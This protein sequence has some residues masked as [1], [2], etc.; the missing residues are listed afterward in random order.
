LRCGRRRAKNGRR[1]IK[2]GFFV[3]KI[4]ANPVKNSGINAP[5]NRSGARDVDVRS[6]GSAKVSDNQSKG[7]FQSVNENYA[8]NPNHAA[9][10][11]HAEDRAGKNQSRGT[12]KSAPPATA[13]DADPNEHTAPPRNDQT[14][15]APETGEDAALQN[16]PNRGEPGKTDP[17]ATGRENGRG[18]QKVSAQ[19]QNQPTPPIVILPGEQGNGNPKTGG[20]QT[21][22]IIFMPTG[23]G[24]PPNGN[25]PN[26]P[27][28]LNLPNTNLPDDQ[29][30]IG[31]N[32][33]IDLNLRAHNNQPY[34]VVRTVVDQILRQNDVYL[35]RNAFNR[36]ISHQTLQNPAA[37]LPRE[38]NTFVR[39]ISR[40]VL[41]LLDNSQAN[42]KLIH[43]I[44][45]EISQQIRENVRDARQ[46]FLK[47][48]DLG[49]VH[50][51]NLNVREKMHVAVELL[52]RHLPPKA[53]E[54]LQNHQTQEVLNGLLLARGL[55]SAN[56]QPAAVRNLT[57]FK[58]SVQPAEVSM[59]ALRDV[60]QLVRILIADTMAAKTTPNLDLA[61]QKFVRILL[62]NNELGVLLATVQLAAQSQ[63]RG[64]LIGRSLALA[65]IY[66]LINR[67]IR[68]GEVALREAAPEKNNLPKER[69]IFQSDGL[70]AIE[71]FDE[72]Q[73][74]LNKLRTN[75]SAGALRQFLE[76]NPAF[77]YDNSASKFDN[78]DDARR[79]QQDFID[80][81]HNDIE[82]WL[83]SGNHRFVKDFDFDKPVGVVVER[84]SDAVFTATTARFVLVRDGSVQGWHFLKSFLVK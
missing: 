60:G 58:T 16:R 79:A 42:G 12:D 66:E 54:N 44:S 57:A 83:K 43:Q 26:L 30:P 29:P 37:N 20:T 2:A 53:L 22:P 56:E 9:L 45:K 39:N 80:L 65:Q 33:R 10:M 55:V 48:A 27:P 64:G 23:Q 78:P 35:S 74:Q 82:Q 5:V 40:Q 63:N 61:V 13:N 70:S 73:I 8:K 69:N 11:G 4:M 6:G 28:I 7:I 36:L 72:S 71:D 14:N 77:V 1:K 31:V 25:N 38:I 62:A 34:G 84:G 49:A 21:P 76:L 18:H 59:T 17:A 41:P 75:K 51:K 47:N 81:Y 50:F 3:K 19:N 46:A 67:L 15:G 24:N 68:A 52:P 32:Y